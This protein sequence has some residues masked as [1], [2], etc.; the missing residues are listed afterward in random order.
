MIC[1]LLSVLPLP[2]YTLSC[3]AD[4]LAVAAAQSIAIAAA[5]LSALWASVAART[6][7][8]RLGGFTISLA[9][10]LLGL[11]AGVPV[12][13]A[14]VTPSTGG[15][16]AVLLDLSESMR[17]EGD[18]RYDTARDLLARRLATSVA[19]LEAEDDG[20]E[21]WEGR[22]F[23]FAAGRRALGQVV[24]LSRLSSAVSG[25]QIGAP[26]T[27]SDLSAGLSEAIGWI[28]EGPGPGALYLLTD[29]W[30]TEQDPQAEIAR[31]AGRGL[32]IHVLA[33][34]AESVA[35]GL[36]AWN[37]GPEQVVSRPT[38]ARLV[39]RGPG[40]LNWSVDGEPGTP[41]TLMA[42]DAAQPI[43]LPLVFPARGFSHLVVSH[44]LD[45]AVTRRATDFTL[46]RGPARLLVFGEGKWAA[47]L[48]PDRFSVT[49]AKPSD[50]HTLSDF[51]I[52]A[53]D[54]LEPDAFE[55]AFADDLLAAVS[56][57]TGL[58]LTNG[59]RRGAVTE[60]QRLA[61]WEGTVLGPILPVNSDPNYV[62]QSPP[63]RV[64]LIIIDTSGSMQGSNEARARQAAHRILESLRPQD[65]LTIL[66]FS[67]GVGAPF[68][69]SSLPPKRIVDAGRY[70][71]RLIFGGGTNMNA[72]ITA[73]ARLRGTNCDLFVIGD[74]GYDEGQVN[75]SPICKTT[76]IGVEGRELPGFDTTWGQQVVLSGSQ[77]LGDITFETFEPEP[78]LEFWRS[79]PIDL[80]AVDLPGPF[81]A[82]GRVDGLSLAFARPESD[83]V[84]IPGMVPPD[85]ALVFR[86][87]PVSP[88][89]RT[90]V[91]MGDMT[92][93]LA[94]RTLLAALERLTGWSEPDRFDIRMRLSGGSLTAEISTAEGW[95]R[96]RQL[97]LSLRYPDG[98]TVPFDIDAT[99]RPGT[100]HGRAPVT[101]DLRNE[102]VI[103]TLQTDDSRGQL[104]PM[105]LPARAEGP[106]ADVKREKDSS[107]VNTVFLAE[108]ARQ[109][110][111][112]DLASAAPR[113]DVGGT[114]PEA[115]HV[116]PFFAVFSLL[117]LTLGL[118]LGGARR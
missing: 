22:V 28:S 89:L 107:G 9:A 82:G 3:Q 6:M 18:A 23:G 58:F 112:V 57:G 100:F 96:P 16:V 50:T 84:L 48:P 31:A 12:A 4:G 2:K 77:Q 24:P 52:V 26:G 90:G 53:L 64:V 103:L 114:R 51:D 65:S 20:T 95:P 49:L 79:G 75:T 5:L 85:P 8:H 29:G 46:V 54:G 116:W 94:E 68:E 41:V 97:S 63:P 39:T 76:A 69:A 105:R 1:E 13:T 87:D 36:V 62:L 10:L 33:F 7:L 44:S 35:D 14:N 93:A 81:D 117:L 30:F 19:D 15:R 43:R 72:A 73:A 104:I 34:G 11:A 67:D 101:L 71:D 118:W 83:V 111:G 115:N 78:R 59:P 108:I 61:D 109:T 102:T 98:K 55:T 74:G 25:A 56:G 32:P 38:V 99:D 45:G 86:D 66:P 91:F 80:R 21:A 70:I 110:G 60:P 106:V 113:H 27:A 42:G 47:N 40:V 37:L 17:R 92:N 88:N